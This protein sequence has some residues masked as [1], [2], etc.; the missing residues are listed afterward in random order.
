[1][2]IDFSNSVWSLTKWFEEN[3]NWL[4][5]ITVFAFAQ[6]INVILSTFKSIILVKGTK[7]T[8]TIVNTISY[9]IGAFITALIGSVVKNVWL[10][11]IV[12]FVTNLVGVWVG[13]TVVEKM[14]KVRVWKISATC[15]KE[16]W[17]ALRKEMINAKVRFMPYETPW[18]EKIPFDVYSYSKEESKILSNIFKSYKVKYFIVENRYSL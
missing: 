3:N 5:L 7:N 11:I 1:M 9:T 15:S 12:T 18:L 13:L 4:M 17:E 8:A 2:G 14:K 16:D 6:L 10:T